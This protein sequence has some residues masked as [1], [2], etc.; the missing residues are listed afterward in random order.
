MKTKLKKQKTIRFKVIKKS[1]R[2]SCT[3]NGNSKYALKYNEGEEVIA[4]S[5][6]VGVMCFRT[7][8][9]AQNFIDHSWWFQEKFKIVKVKPLGRMKK[10]VNMGY[11][12]RLNDFYNGGIFSGN[13]PIR[14]T[15]C[16]PG[17][18]VLE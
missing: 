17:V 15:V 3:I 14:G 13:I 16:Y 6:T 9:D 4:R 2:I 10:L 8:T 12:N 7:I 5:E 11:P 18:H 1:S